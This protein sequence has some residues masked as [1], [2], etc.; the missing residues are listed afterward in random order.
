MT[1]EQ[2]YEEARQTVEPWYMELQ[3]MNEDGEFDPR[4]HIGANY[5]EQL[6]VYDTCDDLDD[7]VDAIDCG[8]IK[9]AIRVLEC[10][11]F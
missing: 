2:L 11:H 10:C 1:T 8:D 4:G 7:I 5:E 6:R 9:E 3:D